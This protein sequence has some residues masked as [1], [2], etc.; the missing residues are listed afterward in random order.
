MK[1]EQSSAKL[2]CPCEV[3]L[4]EKKTVE[5]DFGL[6]GIKTIKVCSTCL[7]TPPYNQCIVNIGD[8]E[9]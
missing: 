7:K 5:Y 3:S 2:E 4:S 8:V 6:L 1:L 9:N